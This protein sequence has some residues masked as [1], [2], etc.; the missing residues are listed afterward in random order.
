MIRLASV[1]TS[2]EADL[3]AQYRGRLTA[4]HY[5]ALAA[6]KQCRMQASLKMQVKCTDCDH[7]I[8]A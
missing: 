5:R 1:I 3:L 6:M 4:D 8:S 2:F 7:Q